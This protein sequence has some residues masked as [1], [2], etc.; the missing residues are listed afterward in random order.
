MKCSA[1]VETCDE[2]PFYCTVMGMFFVF[3]HW[4]KL[5]LLRPVLTRPAPT[6]IVVCDADIAGDLDN[7]EDEARPTSMGDQ[8]M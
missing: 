4:P 5:R 8:E 6:T 2:K 1:V 7:K 3:R